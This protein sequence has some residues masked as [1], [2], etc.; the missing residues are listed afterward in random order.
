M[1]S[2]FLLLPLAQQAIA[3]KSATWGDLREAFPAS[4]E[5][6]EVNARGE[7]LPSA[8]F[9][10]QLQRLS[11]KPLFGSEENHDAFY[12]GDLVTVCRS[13]SWRGD[14]VESVL[15]SIRTQISFDDFRL[16]Q[17]LFLCEGLAAKNWGPSKENRDGM[18]FGPTWDLQESFWMQHSG[19]RSV[20]QAATLIMAD[21][22]AIK[23]AE[24]AF[25]NYLSYAE[26]TYLKVAP[27]LGSYLRV[28]NEKANTCVAA[29]LNVNFKADLP[30]PFTTYKMDLS[31]LHRTRATEDLITYVYGRGKDIHWMAGYDRY[32]TIRN[33][34]GEPVATM[35]VRQLAFDLSGVPERSADR[36]E[37]LRSG[38][39]NLRRSAENLFDQSWSESSGEMAVVPAFPV[40]CPDK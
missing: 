8:T 19:S 37:G 11:E 33:R 3:P 28:A 12:L 38:I 27:T 7:L 1:L 30:F 14:Y 39:G 4:W 26:N 15:E 10:G 24:H 5:F 29:C 2:L 31:I 13:F 16:L 23:K 34:E 36:Q 25:S 22:P 6:P 21:L 18:A 35:L 9:E 40:I 20:E 32:W 17:E